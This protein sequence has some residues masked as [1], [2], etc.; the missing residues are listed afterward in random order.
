YYSCILAQCDAS[1]CP[2]TDFSGA[3]PSVLHGAVS[4]RT[5]RLGPRETRRTNASSCASLRHL[6]FHKPR[7]WP[8]GRSLSQ[9]SRFL[10]AGYLHNLSS[11]N[12]FS[13]LSSRVSGS[14]FCSARIGCLGGN[15]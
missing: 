2:H 8:G 13:I 1:P 15:H 12:T 9:A 10:S 7:Q 11:G 14:N 5:H 6:L 4:A 3:P